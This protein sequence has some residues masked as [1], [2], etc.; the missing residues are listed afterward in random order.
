METRLEDKIYCCL[1]GGLIGEAMGADGGGAGG[2][3]HCLRTD[4]MW[5]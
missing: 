4:T 5:K 3:R 2:S 1:L